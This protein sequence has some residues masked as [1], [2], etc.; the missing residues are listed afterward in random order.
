[1]TQPNDDHPDM[2]TD[3]GLAVFIVAFAAVVAASVAFMW[4]LM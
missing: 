2:L 1:M 4:E 3:F